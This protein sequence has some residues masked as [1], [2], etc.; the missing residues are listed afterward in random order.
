M[1]K[2]SLIARCVL[3]GI[4]LLATSL[5]LP[6]NAESHGGGHGGHG[7]DAGWW[8]LGI[9]L[10]L[11]WE[12]AHVFNPYY[13]PA[14]PVYYYQASPPPVMVAPPPGTTA[15]APTAPP[16]A[17]N[18]YYCDSARGYYPNVRQCPEGWRMIPA[19]PPGPIR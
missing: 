1:N 6:T 7:G 5:A 2:S 17:A 8:G 3:A 14:Y 18:W 12:A 19:V 11:G 15:S 10:G 16:P 4:I 9:G 13:Y